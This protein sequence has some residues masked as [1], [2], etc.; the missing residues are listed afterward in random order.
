MGNISSLDL[1]RVY[2]KYKTTTNNS[3]GYTALGFYAVHKTNDLWNE[4]SI[5][6]L[7]NIYQDCKAYPCVNIF[8]HKE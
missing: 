5:T 6:V 2:F 7:G 8:T 4:N 1:A 3:S